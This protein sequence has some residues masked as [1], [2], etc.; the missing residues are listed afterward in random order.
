MHQ[1]DISRF[2]TKPVAVSI[3]NQVGAV[4]S[5]Y[6]NCI[7]INDEGWVLTARHV[8]TPVSGEIV[9]RWLGFKDSEI[10]EPFIGQ[11]DLAFA[12][13]KGLNPKKIE[14][15]PVFGLPERLKPGM[16]LFHAGSLLPAGVDLGNL[17]KDKDGFDKYPGV[18]TIVRTSYLQ[19]YYN[20]PSNDKTGNFEGSFISTSS[21]VG[22][23]HS[24]GALIDANSHVY[25][26]L[27][28]TSDIDCTGLSIDIRV[29]RAGMTAMG[30]KFQSL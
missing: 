24:G 2:F 25:G 30:I 18:F 13:L 26:I 27:S 23:G 10:E 3:K 1:R 28:G 14:A 21:P 9:D 12:R 20:K 8:I 15:F 29:L 7:V 17:P 6:G 11:N 22:K 4:N 16:E 5:E 19:T